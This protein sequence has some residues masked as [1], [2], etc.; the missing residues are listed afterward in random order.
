VFFLSLLL[1]P[2]ALRAQFI[3]DCSGANPSAFPTITAALQQAPTVGSSILVNGTCN[4][5]VNVYG[6][7]G[8]NLGA[9]YGQTATI[10]GALTLSNSQNVFLYGPTCNQLAHRRHHR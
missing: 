8:L 1:F 9:F 7:V 5:T 6:M 3:V 10:N 4:E 2:G